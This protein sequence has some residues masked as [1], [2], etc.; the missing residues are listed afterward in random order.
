[1]CCQMMKV[2]DLSKFCVSALLGPVVDPQIWWLEQRGYIFYHDLY[3]FY[4]P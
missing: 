1:M 4:A 2:E 3:S